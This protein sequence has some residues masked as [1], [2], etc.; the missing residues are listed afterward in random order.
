MSRPP[1]VPP[2]VPRFF[3]S[4]GMAFLVLTLL[5]L[6]VAAWTSYPAASI[7]QILLDS[8]AEDWVQATHNA[9]GQLR[10][11]TQ[12][13]KVLSKTQIATPVAVVVPAHYAYGTTLFL[14]LLLASRS[15]RLLRRALAGYTLLLFPQAI[16]LV[17]VILYQI[18]REIPVEL[19]KVAPWQLDGIA[20]GQLFSTVVLP[21][22]APVALWLW[23]EREFVRGFTLSGS[24][25]LDWRKRHCCA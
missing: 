2:T 18:V 13:R 25:H 4:A 8:N 20:V 16:S 9:P 22:L 19:L 3:V 1:R 21:T 5:W 12:F 17:F 11:E 24:R 15:K 23:M 10:A 7:A 14:A 6:Q